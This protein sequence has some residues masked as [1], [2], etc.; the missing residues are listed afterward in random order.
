MPPADQPDAERKAL[1]KLAAFIP[2]VSELIAF[3]DTL[4]DSATDAERREAI[5]ARAREL[6]VLPGGDRLIT[7]TTLPSPLLDAS[8]WQVLRAILGQFEAQYGDLTVRETLLRFSAAAGWDDVLVQFVEESH[9][10]GKP[11]ALP[12]FY[13]GGVTA[14][15]GRR[16]GEFELPPMVMVVA[17][18]HSDFDGLVEEFRDTCY[19]HFKGIRTHRPSTYEDLARIAELMDQGLNRKQ[20]TWQMLAD[21]NPE[22][23]AASQA[24]R[25]ADYKPDYRRERERLRKMFQRLDT[26]SGH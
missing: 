12:D 15:S 24:Q 8:L 20:I 17:A 22:I 2:E 5:L 14:V 23:A 10:E 6:G 25:E 18:P 7:G 26:E 19:T 1:G 9:A 13:R 11:A 21:R 16:L 3:R 4:P